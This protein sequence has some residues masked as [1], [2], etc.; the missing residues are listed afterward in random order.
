MPWLKLLHICA[1]ILW[2]A[3]LLYMTAA[4][5][6]AAGRSAPAAIDPARNGLLRTIFTLMATP[7]ALVAIGSGTA[8][9][10]LQ[11]PV[12]LWLLTKLAVVSLMVLAHGVCGMLVLRTERLVR[13]A[14]S[15]SM[16]LSWFGGAL[17]AGSMLCLGTVAWLVLAKP[18]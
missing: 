7:A 1:V 11:G 2:G 10:L 6:A 17:G 16:W 4:I 12:T 5:A 14:A 3:A 13:A 8:I 9:F 15:P 18:F